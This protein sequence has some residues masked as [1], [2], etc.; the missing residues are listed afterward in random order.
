MALGLPHTAAELS[1]APVHEA[2]GSSPTHQLPTLT[3]DPSHLHRQTCV[4]IMELCP[5]LAAQLRLSPDP[6]LQN[7]FP[8]CLQTLNLLMGFGLFLA[9]LLPGWDGG[10]GPGCWAWSWLPGLVS[11][12]APGPGPW[13]S[14]GTARAG[15]HGEQCGLCHSPHSQHRQDSVSTRMTESFSPHKHERKGGFHWG[16]QTPSPE[17]KTLG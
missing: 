11:R 15:L 7:V 3:S 17:K 14:S 6:G 13:G 1:P 4:P 8:P 16:F 12:S 10:P 2:C 9:S 5:T